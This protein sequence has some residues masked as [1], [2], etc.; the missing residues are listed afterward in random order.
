MGGGGHSHGGGGKAKSQ[1]ETLTEMAAAIPDILSI[2]TGG[3][4][5]K[6]PVTKAYKIEEVPPLRRKDAKRLKIIYGPYTLRAA[7]VCLNGL[8]EEYIILTEN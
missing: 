6:Y 4:A 7:N 8:T 1:S 5:K 2:F 3:A